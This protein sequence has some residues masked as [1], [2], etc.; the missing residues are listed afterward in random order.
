MEMAAVMVAAEE[1]ERR[2]WGL[3]RGLEMDLSLRGR[4]EKDEERESLEGLNAAA[5]EMVVIDGEERESSRDMLAE[6]VKAMAEK[7]VWERWDLG[8]ASGWER[9]DSVCYQILRL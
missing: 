7:Q 2:I 9:D 1:E 4:R 5:M 8:C 3:D 6:A